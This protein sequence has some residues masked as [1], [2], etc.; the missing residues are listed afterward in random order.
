[1]TS[2][3]SHLPLL[4]TYILTTSQ[5]AGAGDM[6]QMGEVAHW[7]CSLGPK[8]PGIGARPS[9]HNRQTDGLLP[10]TLQP[11]SGYREPSPSGNGRRPIACRNHAF[12]RIPFQRRQV[13]RRISPLDL[14]RIAVGPNT[15]GPVEHLRRTGETAFAGPWMTQSNIEWPTQ[16]LPAGRLRQNRQCYRV[17]SEASCFS[18]TPNA[19][20]SQAV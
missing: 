6:L 2:C 16:P 14:D 5:Q 1:M 4:Q 7:R 9:G 13:S 11:I 12:L 15:V 3:G 8:P 10:K 19:Q 18:G 20:R 17:S